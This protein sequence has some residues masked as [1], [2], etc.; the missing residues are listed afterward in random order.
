MKKLSVGRWFWQRPSPG[1]RPPEWQHAKR[2]Q[3]RTFKLFG[4]E[5]RPYRTVKEDG[6][7]SRS[8]MNGPANY[9]AT[10]LAMATALSLV[11][12]AVARESATATICWLTRMAARNCEARGIGFE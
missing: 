3:S 5:P 7:A 1:H 11:A 4:M 9:G 12:G 8:G 10:A 2:I 6:P